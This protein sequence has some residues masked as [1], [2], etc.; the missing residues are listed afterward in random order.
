M[1]EEPHGLGFVFHHAQTVDQQMAQVAHG[2][3]ITLVSGPL[4][5]ADGLRELLSYSIM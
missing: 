1:P 3:R 2:L 4:G 5:V